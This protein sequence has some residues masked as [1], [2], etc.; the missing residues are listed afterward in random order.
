VYWIIASLRIFASS[1]I[2]LFA[3]LVWA[4]EED[5]SSSPICEYFNRKKAILK[6]KLAMKKL[7]RTYLLCAYQA[8]S[9]TLGLTKRLL[10][11]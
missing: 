9:L 8:P 11:N 5:Q 6:V 1:S 3:F 2:L 4:E 10:I 7:C